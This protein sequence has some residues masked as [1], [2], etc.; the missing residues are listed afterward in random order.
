MAGLA[1]EDHV[2]LLL[3][4]SDLAPAP[5]PPST[6]YFLNFLLKS[7]NA[8]VRRLRVREEEFIGAGSPTRM[9]RLRFVTQ[10]A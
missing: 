6:L 9:L 7:L 3:H 2:V 8:V 1:F 4:H 10:C 5:R